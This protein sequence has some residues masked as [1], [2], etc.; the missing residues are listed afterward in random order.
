MTA[1]IDA[2]ALGHPMATVTLVGDFATTGLVV[3]GCPTGGARF[4]ATPRS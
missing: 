2:A 4:A 1:P 3:D